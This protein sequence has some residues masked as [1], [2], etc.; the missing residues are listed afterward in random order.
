MNKRT[1]LHSYTKDE[2]NHFFYL[3]TKHLN[4]KYRDAIKSAL[5]QS[6]G[7]KMKWWTHYILNGW[8]HYLTKTA[9][10]YFTDKLK[11]R[12]ISAKI[13]E[14]FEKEDWNGLEEYLSKKK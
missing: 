13:K 4:D 14:L 1:T 6:F 12:H 3:D 8:S 5:W 2:I 7:I 10:V 11:W 9:F